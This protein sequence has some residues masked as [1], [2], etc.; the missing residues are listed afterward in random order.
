MKVASETGATVEI[1]PRKGVIRIMQAPA[2]A[3]P[4][5]DSAKTDTQSAPRWGDTG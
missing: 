4:V 2:I 1:H 5:D 3:A